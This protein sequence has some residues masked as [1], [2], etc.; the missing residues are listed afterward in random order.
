LLWILA[1][2]LS[3]DRPNP[4]KN[5]VYVLS[6][7]CQHLRVLF[8]IKLSVLKPCAGEGIAVDQHFVRLLKPSHPAGIKY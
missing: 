2:Q 8:E 3:F 5:I 6:H 7:F 4:P 1:S